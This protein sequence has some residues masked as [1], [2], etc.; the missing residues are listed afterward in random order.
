MNIALILAGGTGTRLGG[1]IPKQYLEVAG[2]PVIAYCLD[3]FEQH[4]QIDKLQIVAESTWHPL[5]KKWVSGNT[6]TKLQGFSEP[7]KNRQLSIWN[8]LRDVLQYAGEEDVV[9]VHDAARP[10]VPKRIITDCLEACRE[11]EGALT[12]LP[13]KDTVYYGRDGKIESL[14]DRNS[15]LAGQAPEAFRLGK[16]YRANEALLPDRILRINGSTEPAVLAGMDIC[17]V[18]GEEQNFK[19]TTRGDLTRFEQIIQVIEGGSEQI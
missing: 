5:I 6:G 19:I 1:E 14:L 12:V 16:Y 10:L 15:L 18:A 8:G 13:V 2:K 4:E 3:T 17:C 9:I 7:G 11:H